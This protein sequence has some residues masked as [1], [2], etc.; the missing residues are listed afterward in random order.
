[1]RRVSLTQRTSLYRR[2]HAQEAI[3]WQQPAPQPLSP[4]G[5]ELLSPELASAPEPED[6]DRQTDAELQ[7]NPEVNPAP[8][9]L[10]GTPPAQLGATLPLQ[11]PVTL[12]PQHDPTWP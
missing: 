9:P 7:P 1:M 4:E 2:E 8:T 10:Q 12:H 11:G 6:E 3:V 5:L